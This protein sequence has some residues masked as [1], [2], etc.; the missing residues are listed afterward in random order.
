MLITEQ[1]RQ[2]EPASSSWL[3]QRPE[4]HRDPLEVMESISEI[5]RYCRGQEIY[6][7]G[8]PA[9]YWYRVISGAARTCAVQA[10]GRRRIVELLLPGDFFGF[11]P[12]DRNA[13]DVE[14]V[15]EDTVVARYARC[16]AETLAASDSGLGQRIREIAFEAL[17]RSQ[18]RMLM[19]GQITARKKVGLF[20]AELARRSPD[21][22][23]ETVDLPMSRYDIADYLALSV[24]T[25]SRALTGLRQCG[26]I[27]LASAHQVRIID[28]S[29]LKEASD[30]SERD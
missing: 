19:L 9:E 24:E 28:W 30:D 27:A 23:G 12:R 4:R 16:R 1:R 7:R 22:A 18:A 26:A 8:E 21:G 17:L 5:M 29:A 20:V 3:R 25:V 10:D 15:V 11:T 2:D 13:F 14:A 6:G